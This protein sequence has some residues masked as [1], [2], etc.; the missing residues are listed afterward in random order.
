MKNLDVS[1]NDLKQ[2][3]QWVKESSDIRELSLSYDGI[4]LFISRNE[5]TRRNAVSE[6]T[7]APSAVTSNGGIQNQTEIKEPVSA[8][9]ESP[10]ASPA[11][12]TAGENEVLIKAPMV[13]TF[14]KSPKPGAPAF[15][16]VGQQVKPKSIVCIIEV[17]KLMNNLEAKVDGRIKEIYVED[18]QPVEFGQ[19]IML[20][21][22][23]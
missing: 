20:I 23:V 3:T 8:P 1:L 14:Y 4:E 12:V 18:Q 17:M 16:E 15:V 5:N 13:G 21:E 10:A 19:P 7:A 2:L 22:K 6:A 9:V 11:E